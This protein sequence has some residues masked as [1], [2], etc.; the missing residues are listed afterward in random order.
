MKEGIHPDYYQATVTCNCGNT[1]VTGSTRP[2]VVLTSLTRNTEF[3]NKRIQQ[4]G[5]VK[6]Q[7][8]LCIRRIKKDITEY[9]IFEY[10]WSGCHRRRDDEE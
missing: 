3:S 9:E 4:A 7:P 2:E 5:I 8:I 1:F 6:S 10:W